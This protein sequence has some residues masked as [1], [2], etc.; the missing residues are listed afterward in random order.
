M[1]TAGEGWT[2]RRQKLD[3]AR[4]PWSR[5]PPEGAG[6]V[7]PRRRSRE[8]P[9]G[10]QDGRK[11]GRVVSSRPLRSCRRSLRPGPRALSPAGGEQARREGCLRFGAFRCG[12]TSPD[13]WAA[14]LQVRDDWEPSPR[15]AGDVC[16]PPHRLPF[17][18]HEVRVASTG[19]RQL[20]WKL[21]LEGEGGADTGPRGPQ[22]R[23]TP[24]P[25]AAGREGRSGPRAPGSC[26]PACWAVGRIRRCFKACGPGPG[27][28]RVTG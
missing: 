7:T 11:R 18:P 3:P 28:C 27:V 10:L 21:Q 25:R 16:R 6:P 14:G 4:D 20:P 2:R 9:S 24:G 19:G 1:A 15:R 8:A 13:S 17:K 22:L 23:R 26:F 5:A 12:L